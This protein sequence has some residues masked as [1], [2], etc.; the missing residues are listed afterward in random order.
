MMQAASVRDDPIF[1]NVFILQK[2]KE[3]FKQ[4]C[5]C[6]VNCFAINI[7]LAW[8]VQLQPTGCL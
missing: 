1:V 4:E 7:Y 6:L 8:A 2:K 5:C 3:T